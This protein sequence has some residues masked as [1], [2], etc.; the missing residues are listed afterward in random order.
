MSEKLISAGGAKIDDD[1]PQLGDDLHTIGKNNGRK[2]LQLTFE[3]V[4]ITAM[5]PTG[6]C[7]KRAKNALKEPKVIIDGV[8]GT[9]M[10]GQLVAIIGASGKWTFNLWLT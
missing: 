5:P 3:D 1:R 7:A 2:Y 10:P 4:Q 9:I 6:R 8:S